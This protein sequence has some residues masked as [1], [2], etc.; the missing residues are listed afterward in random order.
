MASNPIQKRSRQSFLIGFLLALIIMA[1]VVALLFTR[2]SGLE[3][4]KKALV[5]HGATIYTLAEDVASGGKVTPDMLIPS[6]IELKDGAEKHLNQYVTPASFEYNEETG[7]V[8]DYYAKGDIA[9]GSMILPGMIYKDGDLATDDERRIEY[10]MIVLPS[11]LKAGDYVDIRF[12]LPDGRDYI[13]LSKKYIEQT[14]AKAIW[15]DVSEIDILTMNSAIVESY[16]ITGS[17]LYAT[18][19]TDPG[20][21]EAVTPTYT[22]NNEVL[23][24]I[25]DEP[26]ILAEA[27][28]DLANRWLANERNNINGYVNQT[29]STTRNDMV[30]TGTTTETTDIGTLRDELASQLEGTGLIG[31]TY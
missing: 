14:T 28:Q 23:A 5:I 6:N 27:K 26:N 1:V 10:N 11:Q 17:K 16:Y 9:A 25:A 8:C 31:L 29:D 30:N 12:R 18:I 19:Y 21:Q 4:E 2:I 3:K 13:V 7:E 24:L 22:V 20:M 15:I